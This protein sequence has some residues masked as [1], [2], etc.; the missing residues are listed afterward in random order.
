MFLPKLADSWERKTKCAGLLWGD[1]HSM[2]LFPHSFS[3]HSLHLTHR[4]G[5]WEGRERCA[6][7]GPALRSSQPRP[8]LS[9]D[10]LSH[11]GAACHTAASHYLV[12]LFSGVSF[13]RARMPRPSLLFSWLLT[14]ALDICMGL[15]SVCCMSRRRFL[16]C[17]EPCVS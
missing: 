5:S 7:E 13:L 9:S 4:P 16:K 17:T 10:H 3:R 11:S 8:S 2:G 14:S 12:F 15:I 6:Q 1:I